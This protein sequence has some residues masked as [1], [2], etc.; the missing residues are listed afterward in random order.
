MIIQ[1]TLK[2][3]LEVGNKM[4][5]E[6]N[7]KVHS[8]SKED[9]YKSKI[10]RSDPIKFV[11]NQPDKI[12]YVELEFKNLVISKESCEARIFLNNPSANHDTEKTDDNGYVDSLYVFGHGSTCYGG[13]GHCEV[14]DRS[15]MYDLRPDHPLKPFDEF[16]DITDTFKKIFKKDEP[17]IITIVPI[18]MSCDEMTDM[19]NVFKFEK[20]Y[21]HIYCD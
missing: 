4:S 8:I 14:E 2:K 16:L 3:L 1:K 6:T 5:D 19:V 20:P 18:L 10:Y 17:I 11:V 12:N 13:P 7:H 21:V 9:C 15:S